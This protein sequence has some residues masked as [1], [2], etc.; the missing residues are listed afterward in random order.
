MLRKP[1]SKCGTI[2]I[3]K[4]RFKRK[5]G[6][7]LYYFCILCERDRKKDSYYKNLKLTRKYH[8]EWSKKNREKCTEASKAWRE[9]N[10]IK[11]N[12]YKRQYRLKKF[13]KKEYVY[14]YLRAM[15]RY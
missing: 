4:A 12:E 9:K 8:R 3:P 11:Y 1:C 15:G 10:R 2:D 5:E 6:Y 7:R 13:G 14:S